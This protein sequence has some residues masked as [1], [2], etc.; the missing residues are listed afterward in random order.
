MVK[1][2]TITE[3]IKL[4]RFC[5]FGYVQRVEDNRLPKKSI[6]YEFGSNKSER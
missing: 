1:N 6:I 3:T 4:N 2:P 5:W